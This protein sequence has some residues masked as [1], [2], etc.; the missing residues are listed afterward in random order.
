MAH[1]G[2]PESFNSA[3]PSM[4]QAYLDGKQTETEA[5]RAERLAR[6]KAEYDF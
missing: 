5:E 3:W 6:A 2:S 1:G 4:M